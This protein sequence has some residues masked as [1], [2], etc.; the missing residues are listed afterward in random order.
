MRLQKFW[1]DYIP[2]VRQRALTDPWTVVAIIILVR[3]VVQSIV[4]Q[5]YGY[6]VDEFY[7]LACSRR[8]D[9]G[10]VDQPPLSIWILYAVRYIAGDSLAVIRAPM[11]LAGA[12][13][14]YFAVKIAR[15]MGAGRFAM[16]LTALLIAFVPVFAGMNKFYSMNSFDL[17]FWSGGTYFILRALRKDRLSDWILAGCVL[18]LGLLNK[19]SI[20]FPGFALLSGM[21]FT[22]H[23][24]ML[25]RPGPYVAGGIALLLFTPYIIW[26]F[27]HDW[28]TLEFMHNAA[29]LKNFFTPL[30]FLTGQILEIHPL[31]APVWMSGVLAL[32]FWKPL[33]EFQLLGIGYLT[34]LA[35]FLVTGAKT[36]YLAP[37]YPPLLAA[38]ALFLERR[39]TSAGERTAKLRMG[40]I[41][42]NM[43]LFVIT[44]GGLALLPMS[45]PLLPAHDYLRYQRLLGIAPPQLEQGANG[46]MPQHFADMFGWP[47]L[48]KAVADAYNAQAELNRT[49][50]IILA[51]NYGLAGSLE[52]IQSEA[53]L[54]AIGSGHNNYYLWGPPQ[55]GT[56]QPPD[57][58]LLVGF[59]ASDL[60]PYCPQLRDLA[61]VSCEL[62]PPYRAQTEILL[63]EQPGIDIQTVW[64]KLKLFI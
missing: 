54:P 37:A 33:R 11:L 26:E 36:Y 8:P 59:D 48:Q 41:L 31:F 18:G 30:H 57:Y 12:L 40:T 60:Q 62:C 56:G 39:I 15:L 13:Q 53:R 61:T 27:Q 21:L 58:V 38:G 7:Y 9:W 3:M 52:M 55:T 44:L 4:I 42:L 29:T 14:I 22:P 28:P 43:C 10:Y 46:E 49:N 2:I 16:V 35:L 63:C 50:T 17:V 19:I 45:L 51:R 34:L 32:L 1:S 25:L 24:R 6:F 23:R 5:R 20:L 47:D 64:P